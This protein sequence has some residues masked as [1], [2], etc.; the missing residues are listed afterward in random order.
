LLALSLTLAGSAMA[1]TVTIVNTNPT[2]TTPNT[3]TESLATNQGLYGEFTTSQNL[4][5]KS[6]RG[7]MELLTGGRN[8]VVDVG[9]YTNNPTGPYNG[10]TGNTPG[11]LVFDH[12]FTTSLT[13]GGTAGY[14]GVTGLNDFLA[15]GT[16]WIGF[17]T[18]D[19]NIGPGPSYLK[20]GNTGAN[21]FTGPQPGQFTNEVYTQCGFY[22]NNGLPLGVDIEANTASSAVPVP[23][24]A[25]LLGSGLLGLVGLGWKR[26]KSQ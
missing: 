12:T 7:W 18:T 6:M 15:A 1:T 14:Q 20:M 4:Y 10:G 24:S 3:M 26:K 5:V 19:P 9:I 16:Y 22:N 25:L 13:A 21:G 2:N 8:G 23:P 17:T 11:T